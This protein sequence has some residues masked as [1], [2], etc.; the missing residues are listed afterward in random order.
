M[1]SSGGDGGRRGW[2]SWVREVDRGGVGRC[3]R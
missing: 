1:G 3:G 2:L